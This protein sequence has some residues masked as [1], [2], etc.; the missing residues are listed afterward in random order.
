M[1]V[2]GAAVKLPTGWSFQ[3][4]RKDKKGQRV[5]AMGAQHGHNDYQTRT[6]GPF[7]TACKRLIDGS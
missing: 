6:W 2:R 4:R 5:D 7:F 1:A 3:A